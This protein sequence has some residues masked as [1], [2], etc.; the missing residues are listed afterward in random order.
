VADAERS[1]TSRRG[2]PRQGKAVARHLER[3]EELLVIAAEVFYELGFKGTRLDDIATEAGIAQ[4]SLYHYFDS[5]E[6]IY[7]RLV[8]S[9]QCSFD[10]E[11]D[12][13]D[14]L[15]PSKR[16]EAFAR[17]RATQ[18]AHNPI[19]LGIFARQMVKMDGPI[20]N[21]ARQLARTDLATLRTI[22]LQGQ[23]SGVF[24]PGDPDVLARLVMGSWIY[25]VEW[26]RPPA[27]QTPEAIADEVVE[28][29][30]TSL[31]APPG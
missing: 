28:F 17:A 9:I 25:L 24:R 5:K 6:H 30:M 13:P 7:Q 21:W 15:E 22:I 2:R 18:V 23:K 19:E 4:G 16:L 14:S 29:V 3:D 1:P 31:C 11:L 10:A 8:E 12:I 20:G 27:A 26:Y